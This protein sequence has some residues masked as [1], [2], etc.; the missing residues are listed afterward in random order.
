[1]GHHSC[2]VCCDFFG[3]GRIPDPHAKWWQIW[4][5][6]ECPAC[7]GGGRMRPPMPVWHAPV[8]PRVT[9]LTNSSVG[10]HFAVVDVDGVEIGRIPIV[11]DQMFEQEFFDALRQVIIKCVDGR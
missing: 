4:R 7:D 5:S 3:N 1:M 6:V 2:S 9:I 8:K 10:Q 11:Y